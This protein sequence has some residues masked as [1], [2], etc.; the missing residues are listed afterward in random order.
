MSKGV[1]ILLSILAVIVLLVVA[2]VIFIATFDW[3][4]AKPWINHKV[5]EELGRPFAINGDLSVKWRRPPEA[6]GWRGWF[7]W[8]HVMAHDIAIANPDWAKGKQLAHI[9]E[10][11]FDVA[12]PP[13]LA[14]T[15]S[16]PE[17]H[18]VD[19]SGD[20]ERR[21]DGSNTWTF[22]KRETGKPS[23]WSV[24]YG[25]LSFDRGMV[26]VRDEIK[27]VDVQIGVDTLGQPIP[28]GEAMRQ[29]GETSR[30][31][32]SEFVGQQGARHFERAAAAN[33]ASQAGASATT[34][35]SAP[36][37]DSATVARA[38]ANAS[39]AQPSSSAA[40][41][42]DANKIG[43]RNTSAVPNE[44]YRL[45]FTVKGRYNNTPVDG[46]GRVGGVLALQDKQAPYP[47][48]ADVR[49]GD[50]RIAFV[51]SVT[52]PSELK[53]V[54]LR[55]W[56]SGVSMAK[57]YPLTGV[58]LPDTKPF[59]TEGR[60]HA[61]L[62]GKN[63]GV[64][65][66]ENFTGRVGGSD[67][68]GTLVYTAGKPRPKLS[69]DLTSHALLFDDLGPLIGADSNANKKQRGESKMQPSDKVLPV[70]PFRTERWRTLDADVKFTGERIVR[71]AKLPINKLYTHIVL[72]NGVLSLE[73]LRFGVAGG[74]VDSTI[75]LDGSREPM[76]GRISLNL[77]HL[78][79]KQLFPTFQP[80]QTSF[81]EV[82]GR[83]ALTASGNSVAALLGTSS[84]EIKML[85]NDGAISAFLMEAAG[86]NVANAVI[87][88]LYG[89]RTVKINCAAADFAVKDGLVDPKLFLFDTD[90][91]IINVDGTVNLKTEALDIGVH[92][93][94]KGVRIFSLR[95]P[96][97]ARG[98]LKNPHI[99][100]NVLPL[101]ARAGGAVALGLINPLAALIPLI[102]PSNNQDAPCGPLLSQMRKAPQSGTAGAR[103]AESAAQ[104]ASGAAE[105]K[106]PARGHG[107]LHR[108]ANTQTNS[109]GQARP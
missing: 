78:K 88:K 68:N 20:L 51:G 70:E 72:Q 35:A 71:D 96:L 43:A 98:T 80:M 3:N 22:K 17:I 13:L 56:F 49:V 63:S 57:L 6:H 92:P 31:Q 37:G 61:N 87:E 103:A 30:K 69:G 45:A 28:F 81:G 107:L 33:E 12:I 29:Q 76:R 41:A 40:N 82:N 16:I 52:S 65:R 26:T 38:N 21:A 104:A 97:Y 53:E 77:A 10:V 101:A 100:V 90:D 108:P 102:A 50:V 46:K 1:K 59:A 23:A 32:S 54:D 58:A 93:H 5:S 39:A 74:N 67:L 75:R 14:K 9:G 91:S 24:N 7:P 15:V 106:T 48:Q 11:D 84:G 73:P 105:S 85:V 42:A 8:P 79:L 64:Y 18:L 36:R 2:V 62:N 55:V 83:A 99:G 94:T 109:V 44:P 25:D 47:V 4:R 89:S 86:L 95:S 60:L 66:Y 27:K 34:V 19:P